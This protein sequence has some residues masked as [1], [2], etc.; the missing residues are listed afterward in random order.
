MESGV[1]DTAA[2]VA[3]QYDEIFGAYALLAHGR[4][5]EI[6]CSTIGLGEHPRESQEEVGSKRKRSGLDPETDEH[7]LTPTVRERKKAARRAV[8][9]ATKAERERKKLERKDACEAAK[10]ERE[11][12]KAERNAARESAKAAREAAKEEKASTRP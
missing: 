9:E 4:Q 5:L 8:C 12:K 6:L 1:Q 2:D 11:R 7:C 10:A 3:A